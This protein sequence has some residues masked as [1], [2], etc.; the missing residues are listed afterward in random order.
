MQKD[1][2]HLLR[3]ERK[4]WKWRGIY[5]PVCFQCVISLMGINWN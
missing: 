3:D 5:R 1:V 4:P 2:S